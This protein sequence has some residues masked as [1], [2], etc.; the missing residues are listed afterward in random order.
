MFT[1]LAGPWPK[2]LVG[3]PL[4]LSCWL[5]PRLLKVDPTYK[6]VS[7]GISLALLCGMQRELAELRLDASR[8]RRLRLVDEEIY[9]LVL[10]HR[11]A[12][13]ESNPTLA[14][15]PAA[16]S[17]A[18]REAL[19]PLRNLADEIA[20]Y[21]GHTAIVAKTR[22]GKTTLLLGIIQQA[23]ELGHQIYLID[24]K[25]DERL[26]AILGITYLQCNRPD[27]VPA[28]LELLGELLEE[29]GQRQDGKQGQAITLL[30]DEHNLVLDSVGDAGGKDAATGYAR[31]TKRLILQ[32]AA[33]R[34]Y[35]RASN[36]TSRVEDWGWNT[37]VLDSLSFLALGREGA[38]ESLEDLI[39]YQMKGQKKKQ[40]QEEL[41]ALRCLQFSEPLALTTL[42]PLQFCRVPASASL[43]L[44]APVQ[45]QATPP[46]LP[47][48]EH[49]TDIRVQLE[50]LIGQTPSATVR[51]PNVRSFNLESLPELGLDFLD[52]ILGRGKK[53]AT[54]EGWFLVSKLRDVWGRNKGLATEQLRDFLRRINQAGA[55][56]Y[57]DHTAT[58]W[59]PKI[60]ASDLPE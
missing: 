2:L 4:A 36:H 32:G 55:G 15:L 24:G 14:A 40:F 48:K 51:F 30:I 49:E 12:A 27:R 38:Y 29:L 60:S 9:D 23:L 22:S 43:S 57:R 41:D 3:V 35:V 16:P 44:S 46:R 39:Q 34:I 26:K 53:H 5:T 11:L 21:D 18:L 45:Q 50:W 20:R 56:E 13:A 19:P 8:K 28:T 7:A 52:Y 1:R 31:T 6:L 33:A 47:S 17:P 54:A 25:G 42:K 59:R 10:T 58:E 37:G